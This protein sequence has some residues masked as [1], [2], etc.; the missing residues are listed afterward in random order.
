MRSMR[1]SSLILGT[2]ALLAGAGALADDARRMGEVE[3]TRFRAELLRQDLLRQ[4][5][6]AA[7]P[8]PS[9]RPDVAIPAPGA[10]VPAARL[11]PE[12]RRALREQLRQNAI[13]A[14]T[15]GTRRQR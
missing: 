1:S 15:R 9:V 2:I 5:V 4:D 12:E 10:T 13:P 14:D 7:R 3:R 11:T 6:S 8:A